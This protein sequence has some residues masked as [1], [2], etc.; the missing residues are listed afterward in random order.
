MEVNIRQAVQAL[1]H[2][3]SFEMV[4]FEAFANA[5]DAGA[6][7]FSICAHLSCK[8]DIQNLTLEISD[9]GEGF[10]DKRFSK[11]CNL[12]DAEEKSHKGLGRLVYLCY[13]EKVQVESFYEETKYRNFEFSN[14][15]KNH[16]MVK[17]V[18]A[19]NSGTTLKMYAFMKSRL[20]RWDSVKGNFIL[21][22]L[23]EKFYLRLY[24]AKRSGHH[25]SINIKTLIDGIDNTSIEWD[26]NQMPNFNL[27]EIK[28]K[29]DLFESFEL[30]YHVEKLNFDNLSKRKIITAIGV[31]DRSEV[32]EVISNDT[33][34]ENYE[35]IFLLI[36]ESF[37]GSIDGSRQNLKIEETKLST[38][39]KIFRE[40]I[41]D[42]IKQEIPSIEEKNQKQI[43][44]LERNFPHLVGYFEKSE[45]GY[46]AYNEVL[47]KA[48]NRYFKDQ[49]E[50][51][52]AEHLSDEQFDKSIVM[53]ARS[54]AEYII[55]RQNVIKKLKML[56]KKNKESELHNIIAPQHSEFKSENIVQDLYRNNVWLMDDKFMS[57]CTVL[58][59]AEM[60][61]V[62]NYLTN[63]KSGEKDE[64]RP[65]ITLFFSNDPNNS[66]TKVDVVVVELKRLGLKAEQNSIVE[67]QLDTRTTQLAK[68]Y[69]HNIQ[70][71][72][73]YGIVEMDEKY[74]LHLINNGYSPLFSKGNVFYKSKTIQTD[75]SGTHKVIQ[76]SYIMDYN[77]LIEDADCRNSTFLKIIQNKL[78]EKSK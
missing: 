41:A 75:L 34:P 77:A 1:F 72:W 46:L 56:T 20:A 70:R 18:S 23:L 36:S 37:N 7:K 13:F 54:L 10:T 33:L 35:M 40:A 15:F 78:A 66:D 30:Y 27:L 42:V 55:F 62:I 73:F 53:S 24:K 61:K 38:I 4:Y 44:S 69:K 68:Y 45:V 11:F 57:Y 47:S 52:N 59:E 50:I 63:G 76:N 2:N 17:N 28:K 9:N 16:S 12:F 31:D 8:E 51:L 21:N 29:S 43:A 74:I 58:S 67:F 48:Q 26:T 65:D 71:M 3:P 60:T 6:T 22:L 64:D 49:R 14:N 32:V 5:L 39:K 19:H 25:I